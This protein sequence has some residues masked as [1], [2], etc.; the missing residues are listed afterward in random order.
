V[1]RDD[2]L[3]A[4][5]AAECDIGGGHRTLPVMR[6]NDL[7][8][9]TFDQ[10]LGQFGGNPAERSETRPVVRPVLAGCIAIY[11]AGPV[12]KMWRVQHHE[13]E[14]PCPRC[15][16][17]RRPAEQIGKIRNHPPLLECGKHL[18]ISGDE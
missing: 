5:V 13:I 8:A 2:D 10:T 12:I 15:N 17:A 3:G 6:M 11:A 14:P 4:H 7:R 18:R 1:N 16:Q 9:V